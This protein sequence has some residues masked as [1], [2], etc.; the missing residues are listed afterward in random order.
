MLLPDRLT[1]V[2]LKGAP[3]GAG[4]RALPFVGA[5]LPWISGAASVPGPD[6]CLWK[7]CVGSAEILVGK[8]L[9]FPCLLIWWGLGFLFS[10]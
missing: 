5:A 6:M 10:F 7:P 8:E 3:T 9:L 4:G 1:S 2:P